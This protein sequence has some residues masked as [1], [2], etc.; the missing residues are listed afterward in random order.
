MSDFPA[1]LRFGYA[2]EHRL[3]ARSGADEFGVFDERGGVSGFARNL[4]DD[5]SVVALE[6]LPVAKLMKSKVVGVQ[7]VHRSARAESV[8]NDGNTVV[9]EGFEAAFEVF[10]VEV[11][12]VGGEMFHKRSLNAGGADDEVDFAAG[13]FVD[14]VYRFLDRGF[15]YVADG[16]FHVGNE[17][18]VVRSV[19]SV[20]VAR[21]GENRFK[22]CEF[23]IV[24]TL[25]G[26]ERVRG[27]G[28]GSH[29]RA[30][31]G[32]GVVCF[33]HVLNSSRADGEFRAVCVVEVDH[34][35][36]YDGFDVGAGDRVVLNGR[37]LGD[38][39]RSVA[40]EHSA[41][42]E[43]GRFDESFHFGVEKVD[44]RA[45]VRCRRP[46]RFIRN[47]DRAVKVFKG[48]DELLVVISRGNRQIAVLRAC[49]DTAVNA[50]LREFSYFLAPNVRRGLLDPCEEGVDFGVELLC[51]HV[52]IECFKRFVCA[53]D[54]YHILF[55]RLIIDL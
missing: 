21:G 26:Y 14:V 36:G 22:T 31:D 7:K 51:N 23:L 12:L 20:N 29:A 5:L 18:F 32:E 24:R 17:P 28:G 54:C 16:S 44:E 40:E 3:T 13:V 39:A 45:R 10:H 43:C 11:S 4:F 2:G 41:H 19:Q 37:H 25:N 1:V 38:Y 53:A 33:V 42:V 55:L 47:F 50:V 49:A 35:A 46:H 30:V 52:E 48:A 6:P 15:A 34:H 8:R 27:N 9:S